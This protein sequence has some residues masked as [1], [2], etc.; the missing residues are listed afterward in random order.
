MRCWS[1]AWTMPPVRT[2]GR[3]ATTR[4]DFPVN[5]SRRGPA[6]MGL[7]GREDIG[8]DDWRQASARSVVR[9]VD[10]STAPLVD[11]VFLAAHCDRTGS[12]VSRILSGNKLQE[13]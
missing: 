4:A 8:P 12:C 7:L 2:T 5:P 10:V 6:V 3:G 11:D 9:V 13:P 1:T